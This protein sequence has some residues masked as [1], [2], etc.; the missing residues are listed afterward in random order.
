MLLCIYI[1]TCFSVTLHFKRYLV[2]MG[3]CFSIYCAFPMVP[4]SWPAQRSFASSSLPPIGCAGR[5]GKMP[6]RPSFFICDTKYGFIATKKDYKTTILSE[7][8]AQTTIDK[9]GDGA[10]KLSKGQTRNDRWARASDEKISCHISLT[11]ASSKPSP[12][13]EYL[14]SSPGFK[15]CKDFGKW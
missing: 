5:G 14:F 7:F 6:L 10:M 1:G 9:T 13:L 8:L 15:A 2:F 12:N 3:T 11:S 4:V